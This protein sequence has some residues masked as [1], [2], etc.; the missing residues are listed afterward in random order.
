MR[1]NKRLVKQSLKQKDEMGTKISFLFPFLLPSLFFFP[2]IDFFLGY[3]SRRGGIGFYFCFLGDG[4]L[5]LACCRWLAL[6]LFGTGLVPWASA[7][8]EREKGKC[9]Q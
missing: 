7:L 9:E 3:G 4:V 5:A 1:L 2:F 8:S 6:G